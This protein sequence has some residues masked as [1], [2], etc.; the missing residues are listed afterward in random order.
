[1]NSIDVE[2][3]KPSL[4]GF[5]VRELSRVEATS[6]SGDGSYLKENQLIGLA[7]IDTRPLVRRIREKGA[8]RGILSTT[9]LDDDSLI[10][11]QQLLRD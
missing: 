9:D 11:K 10:A 4:S 2:N 8:M 1:M 5:I 3:D 7:G 6:R